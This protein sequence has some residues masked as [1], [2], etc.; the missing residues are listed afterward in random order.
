MCNGFRHSWLGISASSTNDLTSHLLS[1]VFALLGFLSP[2]NRGSLAT[3]MMVCWTIFGGFVSLNHLLLIFFPHKP[4]LESAVTSLAVYMRLLVARIAR[5]MLSSLQQRYQRNFDSIMV[6]RQ[7]MTFDFKF[8]LYYRVSP[9]LFPPISW[10]IRGCSFWFVSSLT[11]C[12]LILYCTHK[13][14]CY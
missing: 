13:A 11:T 3:V 1:L 8:R 10:F 7:K 12:F 4:P 14:R 6:F 5:K 9:Q 2:S